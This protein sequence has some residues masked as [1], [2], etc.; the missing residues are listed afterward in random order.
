MI[1]ISAFEAEN[2]T[3]KMFCCPCDNS[4]EQTCR[5][6]VNTTTTSRLL[7]VLGRGW[8]EESCSRRM[9][10]GDQTLFSLR[11]ASMPI[12]SQRQTKRETHVESRESPNRR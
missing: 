9:E 8:V 5:W 1:N 6:V 7:K 2:D 10:G 11:E 3:D 12:A 4:F